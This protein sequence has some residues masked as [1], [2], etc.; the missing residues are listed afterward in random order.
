MKYSPTLYARS[1][2]DVLKDTEPV[3][4]DPVI[5]NFW[6]TV[7]K[8]GDQSRVD[9]IVNAFEELVV[10]SNGGRMV[11]IETAREISPKL[12]DRLKV[13]FKPNDLVRR[14]IDPK[15]IAGVRVELDGEEEL[16]Y[17]LARKFR[18]MFSKN[19]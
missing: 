13:L 19:I 6:H 5:K 14:G 17:S 7:G 1:L 9:S 2:F 8:N 3:G 12:L 16:D 15:L 18:K 4:Y 10:R 11:S